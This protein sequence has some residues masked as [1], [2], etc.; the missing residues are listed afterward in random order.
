MICKGSRQERGLRINI[1]KKS[2]KG[3]VSYFTID[4]DLGTIKAREKPKSSNKRC[5]K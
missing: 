5:S 1:P 4:I 3:L 2:R